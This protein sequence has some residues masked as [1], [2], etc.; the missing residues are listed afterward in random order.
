MR[1]GL[2][3]YSPMWEDKVQNEKKILE[4]LSKI[5]SDFDIVVFPE[6]TLTGFSMN[7][8]LAEIF[9]VNE[10]STLNFF[11]KLAKEFSTNIAAGFI[12]KEK[13]RVFNTLF[14]INRNGEIISK[15]RK[16]HLFSFSREDRY[17]SAGNEPV[18]V[19]NEDIKIGLSI[20]YDLR[21]PE[22][23]RLYAKSKVDLILNIANWPQTRIEHFVHLLKSRAIENQC[24]MIGVNRVGYGGREYYDGRSSIYDPLGNQII[25]SRDEEKLIEAEIDLSQI[26]KVREQFPFLDDIKLI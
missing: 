22:L 7:K 20:C 21:F 4:I 14:F 2:F 26:Q 24:F 25:I 9:E 10:S 12:E 6:M 17:Y 23:F 3:Q 8:S 19:E 1:V 11:S 13:D 16:I 5:K 18:I 15:Y